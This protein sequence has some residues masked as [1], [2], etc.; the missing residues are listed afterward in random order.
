MSLFSIKNIRVS[1]I[2]ACVP[3]RVVR[4]VD[5]DLMTEK[6]KQIFINGTGVKERRV[7]DDK[8]CTSDL[9]FEAASKIISDREIDPDT[10]DIVVFVSQSPD[11]YLPATSIL[12]QQRLGLKTSTIA[13]DMSLGCC[14]YIYGM[15]VISNFLTLTGMKRG[16]LLC[17]DKSS[18]STNPKDKS[19]YPLFGDAGTATMLEFD[20]FAEPLYFN[21]QSDG[22]G[23]DAIIIPGGGTRNPLNKN[24]LIEREVAP[25]IIRN[26]RD[27]VLDGV[28][29]FNFALREVK[30]NI[31][32][33]LSYSNQSIT[34]FDYLVMHQA[35][36][37]MNETVRKKLKF[38]IEKTPYSLGK[39]G[40]TSSA[41]IPLTFVSELSSL[42]VRDK[43]MLLSGFGVGFSWG[44]VS[45]RM[46]SDIVVHELSEI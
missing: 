14:G 18:L 10:I 30:P 43:M 4:T 23:K 31:E 19:T 33:L 15:A 7:A 2:S 32:K 13:F 5:Y 16:L 20:P 40:N 26:E 17:G 41:S 38:P 35:N 25:G 36:K 27:L 24:T 28:E 21:L 1:D 12:L 37:L 44:T 34:D 46:G 45:I 11:Y 22:S 6:E 3:K 42:D 39:F 9:C 29:V 8:T